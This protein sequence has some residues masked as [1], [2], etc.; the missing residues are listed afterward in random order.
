LGSRESRRQTPPR[1]GQ[2]AQEVVWD[3]REGGGGVV[4]LE[5]RGAVRLGVGDAGPERCRSDAR[6]DARGSQ[7]RPSG[8]GHQ[9]GGARS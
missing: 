9:R 4:E 8:E 7:T 3:G 6:K 2:R 5:G 1:P